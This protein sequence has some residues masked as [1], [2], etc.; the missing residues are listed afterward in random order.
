MK[1]SGVFCIIY[2]GLYCL[3][4]KLYHIRKEKTTQR[5]RKYPKQRA[6]QTV[7]RPIGIVKALHHAVSEK[8]NGIYS[9]HNFTS[10]I[11]YIL[12]IGFLLSY[13]NHIAVFIVSIFNRT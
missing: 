8:A 12:I 2:S 9:V 5:F 13:V 1:I 10:Y 6:N 7:Y 11:S 4:F 3:Y